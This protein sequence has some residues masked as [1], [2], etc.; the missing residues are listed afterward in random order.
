L[1]S[2]PSK[3]IADILQTAAVGTQAAAT[4][5]SIRI[6]RLFDEPDTQIA[7]YDTPSPNPDPK[8]LLEYPHFQII[9]R[10]NKD[11]YGGAWQK[12][13]DCKDVLLGMFP[14][15]VNSDRI[16]GIIGVGDINFLSYDTN[17]RPLFS[18][19]FQIFLEPAASALTQRLPL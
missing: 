5:W 19:N 8:W 15:V 11:D 17:N 9:V 6:G 7:V 1:A 4:G 13:R 12:A 14:Q 10:G 18:A 16:D 2:P 3:S